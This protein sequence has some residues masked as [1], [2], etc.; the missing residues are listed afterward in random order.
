MSHSL[1]LQDRVALVTGGGTGIGRAAALAFARDGARV[2]VAGRREAELLGTVALIRQQGGRCACRAH[3]C[4]GQ[5]PGSG[6]GD[7]H[8]GPFR[9]S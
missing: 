5:R 8:A 2:V 9:A 6:A 7:D 4:V 3:G 1:R